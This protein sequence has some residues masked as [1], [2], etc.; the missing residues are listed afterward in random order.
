MNKV[1]INK[2]A[3]IEKVTA[4]KDQHRA[5]F[6]KAQEGY[7]AFLVKELEQRLD[8]ANRGVKVDRYIRCDEPEDHTEDYEQA[9]LMAELSVDD[10]L[11][12]TQQEFAWY[13]MDRWTWKQ[14]WVAT[15]STYTAME[16]S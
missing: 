9:L 10:V 16:A 14:Q 12:I 1:R 8:E 4:N 3:F 5:I 11:E 2:V 7:R 13:I 15:A 6:E